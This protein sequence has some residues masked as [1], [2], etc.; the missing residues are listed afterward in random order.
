M[1]LAVRDGMRL[2]G[3][4]WVRDL[5]A[6]RGANHVYM[7]YIG[8]GWAMARL[9]RLR[10]RAIDPHDPWRRWLALDGSGFQQAY[11]RT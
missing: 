10:G 11:V 6:S 5:L 2:S 4:H 8:V 1:A 7:A 3:R 9:P